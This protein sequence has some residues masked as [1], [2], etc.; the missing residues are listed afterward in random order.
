MTRY[1][2]KTLAELVQLPEFDAELA[3]RLQTLH[4]GEQMAVSGDEGEVE[5]AGVSACTIPG[6]R[7]F[8]WDDEGGYHIGSFRARFVEELTGLNADGSPFQRRRT[9]RVQG[10]VR[11]TGRFQQSEEG[12]CYGTLEELQYEFDVRWL[13]EK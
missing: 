5:Q 3:L 11:V 7:I 8:D 10:E 12:V 1:Q 6:L 9:S 13:I 4:M 2:K